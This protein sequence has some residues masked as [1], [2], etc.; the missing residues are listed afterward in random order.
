MKKVLVGE[1]TSAHGIKGHVR[2]FPF[3]D[4]LDRF[5]EIKSVF[6][7]ESEDRVKVKRVG[8][9]KNL[10]LLEIEGITNRN[11]AEKL[12]KVQ[13]FIL[14]EDRKELDEGQF[15]IED[16]IGLEVIHFETKETLGVVK[17]VM[18]Q[19]ANDVLEIAS[20]SGTFLVPFVK[21]FIEEI[22][23]EEEKIFIHVIEGLIE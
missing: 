18:E 1:V 21:A 11:E 3:T 6:L 9:Q 17:N 7:G 23:L 16:L 5:K 14:E 2:V 12:K 15:F 10:V 22:D 13:L 20:S 8:V 4:D 19:S